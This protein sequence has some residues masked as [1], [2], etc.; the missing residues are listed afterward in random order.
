MSP[1]SLFSGID[2]FLPFHCEIITPQLPLQIVNR[3][4][5]D[6]FSAVKNCGDS[7]N[8]VYLESEGLFRKEL[9]FWLA[10]KLNFTTIRIA[11]YLLS[12]ELF[13]RVHLLHAGKE[14]E[15]RAIR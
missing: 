8:R 11:C 9:E 1:G 7:V 2:R 6:L 3:I 10:S 4:R 14:D 13:T 15:N 12:C 5:T